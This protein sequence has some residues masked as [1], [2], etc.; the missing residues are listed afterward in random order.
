MKLM[1]LHI[2]RLLLM[3]LLVLLAATSCY[4]Y[5]EGEVV[6][7]STLANY[8]NITISVS[9]GENPVTRAPQ[10]GE[11]GDGREHGFERENTVSGITVI[12]YKGTGLNDASAKIDFIRYFTVTEANNLEGRDPQGTT[13]NY[14]ASETYRSEARYTTGDQKIEDEELDFKGTYHVLIVANKNII[15]DNCKKGTL[16]SDVL[17]LN[18]NDIYSVADADKAKPD[19]YQQFVMTSERDAIIDFN[20]MAPVQ[21]EGVQ[22][23]LVYRVMKPL[24]IERMSARIDYCTQGA[25]YDNNYNGYKYNLGSTDND[26]FCVITKVT[27]F[28]IYNDQEYLFKRVSNNWTDATPTITYLGD[29]STTNYVV[30]P[31]TAN[32]DNSNT[33]QPVYLSPIAEDMSSSYTQTMSSLSAGQT[34]TDANGYNNVIIAYPKENTLMP[35]SYLKKYATGIAFE[36]KYYANPSA[37]PITRVYY[38]YLRHQGELSMGNYQAHQWGDLIDTE[39]TSSHDPLVPMNYGVVRNNIY[40]ISIEGFSTVEGTI[41]IK[42]EEK[43]WRH[44]DNPVIY[45]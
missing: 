44:V 41:K 35:S 40:R 42:I 25:V 22:N 18:I 7:Y 33:E 15:N 13:Y 34:F 29:E 17:K 12:L 26:G 5:D 27:P 9:A 30:D 45:I 4:N 16:I 37:D 36:A 8:I 10:G 6:N 39:S 32:K 19:Q 2:V 38:H 28:N 24:L 21:K 1:G 23:G 43:K 11:D 31:K 14:Q 3:A 20:S